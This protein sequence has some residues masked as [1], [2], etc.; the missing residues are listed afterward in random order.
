MPKKTIFILLLFLLIVPLVPAYAGSAITLDG[1]V[2][3]PIGGLDIEGKTLVPVRPILLELGYQLS[4]DMGQGVVLASKDQE[5]LAIHLWQPKVVLN[6]EEISG[7][8]VPQLIAGK[9]MLYAEDLGRLL[10]LTVLK[11]PSINTVAFFTT[12]KMTQE[13]VIRQLFAADRMFLRAEYYNNQ[14]FLSQHQVA[15]S[16]KL[17]AKE[18]LVQLMGNYWGS[19][20]IDSLW[21][22][23]SEN[24]HYVGFYR[25]GSIPLS[26]N[27]EVIVKE[28][29]PTR[30]TIEVTLPEWGE[31][32]LS[33]FCKLLYTLTLEKEGKLVITNVQYIE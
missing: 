32:G 5:Q 2:L 18:D 12:P 28:L 19:A 1:K 15:P 21:Q 31:E 14:D 24:G 17:I 20:N 16:P 13:G 8:V 30:A 10:G 27:K 33:N 29:T 7:K 25:E 26:Y 22:A 23:G 9:T 6:G 3:N 4:S 11:E